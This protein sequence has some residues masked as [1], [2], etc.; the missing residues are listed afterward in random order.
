[1]TDQDYFIKFQSYLL[2]ER[3]VA[4]NT[5]EAYK[6]DLDQLSLFLKQKKITLKKL[7]TTDLKD[8]LKILKKEHL[9]AR[10]MA[11]KISCYKTF[12]LYLHEYHNFE[13]SAQDLITPK[14]E[15]KLPL[16]ISEKEIEILFKKADEDK[17]DNGIRNKVMLYLLYVTGMRIS[18]LTNLT[19]SHL[20]LSEGFV[21]IPGKGG[22]ERMVPVPHHM[23]E[24]LH[25]YLNSVYPKLLIRENKKMISD[26][27]F[28]TY[29]SKALKSMSRQSF[30]IY[31]KEVAQQ[32][33]IT[34][35]LSPHKLRHSLATHLLKNG[36]N[37]RSLQM[38]LGHEQ[39]NTVQIYTHVETSH[40][41]KIYD[42]KHPR[43]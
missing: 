5:F 17:T 21:R 41:R 37:L 29:Y 42:D 8:F 34:K 16:Y 20:N 3:R 38:L 13:N 14:L 22:K 33:G 28:P 25:D 2:T 7:I 18:E 15:R 43:S 9:T 23:T 27:L 30:W 40:L 6:S 39:L 11:R 32:A 36:A 12:F 26:Y 10:S 4:K 24:I 1:M 35:D 19:L 31:L